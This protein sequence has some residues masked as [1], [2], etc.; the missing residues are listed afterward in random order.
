M[1]TSVSPVRL[2]RSSSLISWFI[3]MSTAW[4]GMNMPKRISVKT[5]S[6]PGNRHFDSTN[7]FAAPR[8]DEIS[9]AGTAITMLFRNPSRMTGHTSRNV[10]M[11]S[12]SGRFHICDGLTSDG[13]LNAVMINTYT[14]RRKMRTSTPSTR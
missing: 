8:I 3:G 13:S 9:A 10:S 1:W 6:A 5:K 7:P 14:G 4:Y 2:C 12:E 11:E